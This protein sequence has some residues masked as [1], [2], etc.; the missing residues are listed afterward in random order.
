MIILVKQKDLDDYIAEQERL[1]GKDF[2]REEAVF[3][4]LIKHGTPMIGKDSDYKT[5]D[6][7]DLHKLLSKMPLAE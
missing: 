4:F 6:E 2:N 5:F 7:Y 1:H 3:D